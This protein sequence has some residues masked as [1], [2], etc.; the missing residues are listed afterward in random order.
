MVQQAKKQG[1]PLWQSPQFLFLI[2]GIIIMASTVT[3]YVLGVRYIDD[4]QISLLLILGLTMGEL[5]IAFL[6]TQ[7]FERLVEANRLKAEF[8]S[9]VSHQ[10][11][12]PLTNL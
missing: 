4:P 8:V 9:I 5:V 11:R 7:S 1:V 10:L 2:M 3:S 12:S 6:V